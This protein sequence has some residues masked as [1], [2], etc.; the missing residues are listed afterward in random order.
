[1]KAVVLAVTLLACAFA[2]SACGASRSDQAAGGSAV[3][4]TTATPPHAS[5]GAGTDSTSSLSRLSGTQPVA[6]RPSGPAD[7]SRVYAPGVPTLDE[8]YAG[9][10]GLPPQHSPLAAHRSRHRVAVALV[11]CGEES[12][13]CSG[14]SAGMAMAAG[15]LGWDYTVFDG[16]LGVKNG[17]KTAF[18]EAIASL[19][20]A[21]VLEGIDCREVQPQLA[22]ATQAQIAVMGV[23]SVDCESEPRFT[24]QM[25]YSSLVA[26]GS[27][28][29]FRRGQLQA[30]YAIDASQ[31]Q[32]RIIQLTYQTPFGRREQEGQ[33]AELAKCA[34]C[35]LAT[36]VAFSAPEQAAE[37]KLEGD[38]LKRFERALRRQDDANVVLMSSDASV[39]TAGLAQAVDRAGRDSSTIVVGGEGYQAALAL[40]SAGRGDTAEAVARDGS[41]LAWAAID[42]L[43]RYLN[44]R[45]AVAEGV[46]FK[47]VDKQHNLPAAGEDYGTVD[48]YQTVYLRQW[49]VPHAHRVASSR[50]RH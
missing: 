26:S 37:G 35:E 6:P 33:D 12:P 50:S 24:L 30:D 10:E 4:S 23:E 11:S 47:A 44:G 27:E 38:L 22:A 3:A 40:V 16:K 45:P 13:V 7:P 34:A 39:I 31:G 15:K 28:Y 5:V 9:D 21:I 19:P 41:W 49:R 2:L 8:L 20:R 32:A 42:S 36:T 18:Q 1:M 46:G 17:W 14:V 43:A 29:A 25:P 48:D